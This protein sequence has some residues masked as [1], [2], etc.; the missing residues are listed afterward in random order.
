MTNRSTC[1]TNSLLDGPPATSRKEPDR[2]EAYEITAATA[3]Q[4]SS[5]LDN[6]LWQE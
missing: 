4:P 5:P 6:R 1:A 2:S 3:R